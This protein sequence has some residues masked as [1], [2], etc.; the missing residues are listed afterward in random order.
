M[1]STPQ[2]ATMCMPDLARALLVCVQEVIIPTVAIV[3]LS[4]SSFFIARSAVPA[5]VG[6]GMICYLTLQNFSNAVK[7]LLPKV[8]TLGLALTL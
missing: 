7:A 5:R 2:S 1:P 3:I 8:R 4:W 6:M